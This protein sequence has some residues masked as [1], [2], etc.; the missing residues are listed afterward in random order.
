MRSLF[1]PLQR[2]HAYAAYVF[3]GALLAYAGFAMFEWLFPA[4]TGDA[5]APPPSVPTS[6]AGLI[7]EGLARNF[8]FFGGAAFWIEL[9]FGVTSGLL[10]G[11]SFSGHTI[12][13][14]ASAYSDAIYWAAVALAILVLTMLLA[15]KYMKTTAWI[16]HDPARYLSRERRMTFWFVAVGGLLSVLGL[17]ACFGGLGLS[18]ALLVGKTVSQPPGI[19]ITDP[20]KIIR[21]L[22]IF[23]LLVN[24]NLLLAHFI[25]FGVAAWLSISSVQARRQYL[26][27]A[28]AAK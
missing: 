12:S 11:F 27:A 17:F 15:F 24:F 19:A 16:R 8:R 3:G 6:T 13:A 10:L 26:N 23:V 18:V 4:P 22:D 14:G 28:S 7:A 1:E 9:F 20:T 25:G 5:G 2:M 21:A